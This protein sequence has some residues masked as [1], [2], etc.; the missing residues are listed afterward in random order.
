MAV[1]EFIWPG[2]KPISGIKLSAV[3]AGVKYEG[4]L[5]MAL[6]Q[7]CS[8]ASVSG[9]FTRNAFCAEPIKICPDTRQPVF[10][11]GLL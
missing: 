3:S 1:G 8:G 4:R 7:I 6:I 9:V 10:E 11:A 5:D 2:V